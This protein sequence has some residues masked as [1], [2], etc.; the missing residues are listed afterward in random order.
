V[1]ALLA[2]GDRLWLS[3]AHGGLHLREANGRITSFAGTNP[4][5]L[6]DAFLV[7][8]DDAGHLWIESTFGLQRV[9]KQALL[10]VA[11]GHAEDWLGDSAAFGP[12]RGCCSCQGTPS[13]RCSTR[14][15][16]REEHSRS[17]NRFA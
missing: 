11:A 7:V 4:D 6:D 8:D 1:S 2:E 3:P 15:R 9:A 12:R 13:R 16:L 5:L 17:R 14:R 10:D